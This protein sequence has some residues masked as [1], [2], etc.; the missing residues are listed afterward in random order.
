MQFMDAT[1][2]GGGVPGG[3]EGD[4]FF[5]FAVAGFAATLAVL[6]TL[7]FFAGAAVVVAATAGA[8]TTLSAIAE[9]ITSF[10]SMF[11]RGR[12]ARN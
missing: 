12:T 10:I 6:W 4:Y 8:A 9:A 3:R 7:E 1:A 5:G 2:G 11:L